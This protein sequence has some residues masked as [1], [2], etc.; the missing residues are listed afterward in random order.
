MGLC[1]GLIWRWNLIDLGIVDDPSLGRCGNG[2]SPDPWHLYSIIARIG[3]A[4]S[5]V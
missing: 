5:Q 3:A 2:C 4:S 1:A